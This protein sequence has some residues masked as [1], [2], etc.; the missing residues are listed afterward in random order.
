VKVVIVGAGQAGRRTAEALREL[1]DTVEITLLGEETHLPYDRPPLSKAVLLGTDPGRGLFVRE[2]GFYPERRIA[3]RT[4]TRIVGIDAATR[5]VRTEAGETIRWDAL[6]LATGARARRLSVPGAD[7]PRVLTLRTL[8]EAE[9][10]RAR[11]LDRPRVA[12]VGGGLIGLEVAASARALG[13]PVTV[14]EAAGRLLARSFAAP[15]AAV[16]A[17]R[18]RAEGVEIRV[19]AA[20]HAIR[21]VAAGL[22]LETGAGALAADLVVVGIGGVAEDALAT[23]AGAA[24]ANGILTDGQGRTTVSGVYAAG[25]VARYH[26]PFL[27]RATRLESWQVAQSQPAAVARAILGQGGDYD[28]IPWIWTDQFNWNLQ[29]FGDAD[30]DHALV[31]RVASGDRRSWIGLDAQGRARG[32]ALLNQGRDATPLRRLIASGR[33]LDR[34]RLRDPAVELRS[35]L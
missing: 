25:E 5:A 12:V 28:E 22:T 17:A 15:V 7:D 13:C 4:G 2:P 23:A 27:G 30:A 16:V 9:G 34:D 11:L 26:Q 32:G 31:E 29:G 33:V 19:D 24:T 10:L 20:V 1:D 18:H 35:L 21:T 8:T 3:L 6:V 14:L